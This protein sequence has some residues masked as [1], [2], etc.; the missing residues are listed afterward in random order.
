VCRIHGGASP[1]VIAKAKQ[2]M[3]FAKDLMMARALMGLTPDPRMSPE[4]KRLAKAVAKRAEQPKRPVRRA[5]RPAGPPGQ[6]AEPAD[7]TTPPEQVTSAVPEQPAEPAVA[8]PAR[9]VER[10]RGA[11]APPW[12]EPAPQTPSRSL[13]S[14]EDAVADI[15]AANRRARV[16]QRRQIRR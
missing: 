7:E 13:T 15:A 11:G 6:P 1:Q 5:R 8:Q 16:S 3:D 2:R 9:P 12:A 4:A 14:A 10:A